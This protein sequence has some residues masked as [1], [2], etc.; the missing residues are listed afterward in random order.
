MS[1]GDTQR[2]D[3]WLWHARLFKTRALAGRTVGD[4][5]ARITRTGQTQRTEKPSFQV[6]VGDVVAINK[7]DHVR[8]LEIVA[9]AS[10]RGPA[11]EAEATYL[12][13]SPPRPPRPPRLDPVFPREE[14]AGRPTKRDRRQL[15]ALR[16]AA[17]SDRM[18]D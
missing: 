11:P 9:L 15:D 1:D 17:T 10:R 14:G 12:D 8:V 16:D 4:H 6:R 5:G 7:N 3:R 2:L 13:H 18:K